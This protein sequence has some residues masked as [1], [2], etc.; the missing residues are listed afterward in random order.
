MRLKILEIIFL[1]MLSTSVG[2]LTYTL[3]RTGNRIGQMEEVPAKAGDTLAHIAE[4]FS[5]GQ[6]AIRD[7]NPKLKYRKLRPGTLV[8]IPSVFYLPVSVPRQ[9]LVIN[10]R[11]MRAYYY[12]PDGKQVSTYPL[13]V[14][15]KGW[16]TP[17]G[18]T[19]V[20]SKEANPTWHP[21]DSIKA[22]AEAKGQPLPNWVPPGPHNPLGHYAIYLGI[23]GILIHGTTSPSSV[24][25]RSSHG[26]LRMYAAD[27]EDLFNHIP[28]GEVVYLI[29]EFTPESDR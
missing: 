11:E 10:L 7:A 9:G 21:P 4:R 23:K 5:M 8:K 15:R 16:S 29:D 3:P 13:C 27:I 28:L 24:G 26:C 25:E 1:L 18:M 17:R 6:K 20:A 2:A 12:H 19:T 14:G 22:E